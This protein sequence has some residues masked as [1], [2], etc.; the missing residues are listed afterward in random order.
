MSAETLIDLTQNPEKWEDFR[1]QGIVL[2][3]GTQ[4]DLS[5]LLIKVS[6]LSQIQDMER[7]A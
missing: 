7:D 1:E 4:S 6:K 2:A 5:N 3:T